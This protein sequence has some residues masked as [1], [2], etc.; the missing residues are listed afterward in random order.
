MTYQIKFRYSEKATKFCEMSNLLLSYV[1]PFKSKVEIS[2]NFVAFSEYLNFKDP[3]AF[4]TFFFFLEEK[5]LLVKLNAIK[6]KL[7]TD[8][9]WKTMHN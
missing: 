9:L 2:Q 7:I 1:V 4:V 5:E 6:D 3:I 8:L